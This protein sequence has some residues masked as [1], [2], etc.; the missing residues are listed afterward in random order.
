MNETLPSDATPAAPALPP[1]A[2]P[3]V[4]ARFW[5]Q[6]Q[7]FTFSL[8]LF[9]LLIHVLEK[10]QLILQP[11]F[12]AVFIA[13]LI[14]PLHEVLVERGV[15][16]LVAYCL[17]LFLVLGF[18]FGFG[19]IVYTSFEDIMVGLPDYER[20]LD[21]LL[22]RVMTAFKVEGA[23]HMSIR[24]LGIFGDV[25]S[26]VDAL[27][28]AVGTFTGFF[29]GLAVTFVYLVFLIAE[30]M[31]L[32][33][34]LAR[35]FGERHAT[36][37]LTIADTVN[38]AVTQYLAVKTFGGLLAAVL[39]VIVLV[40]FGVDFAILWGFLMFLLNYI[41]YLGSLVAALPIGLAFL[42]LESVLAA[43]FVAIL[44]IAIQQLIGT[45]LE[46]RMAGRRLQVSPLLILL[47]L[48]FWGLLWGVVG[49]ILA[50]PLLV[51]VKAI[52]HNIQETRPLATLMSNE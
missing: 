48:S 2:A 29:A 43:V 6:L 32:K 46:P 24:E 45:F 28:G 5:R 40:G 14:N 22:R 21:G 17:M 3:V 30:K 9:V 41:P 11:L 38:R 37:M 31:S 10:F 36:N 16:S 26:A 39:S 4:S 1:P 12:V 8:L 34:R 25:R 13:Y 52:L 42:Q 44:L 15:P 47:S 7:L 23:A 50:V 18:L 27:R 20:K 35:A 49:M 33:Q 51:V 19:R